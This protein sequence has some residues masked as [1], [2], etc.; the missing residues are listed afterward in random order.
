MH[1]EED[2]GKLTHVARRG[3]PCRRIWKRSRPQGGSRPYS[4]VDLNRAGVPL[5]E[6]VTEPDFRSAEEVRAYAESLRRLLRYLG[7]NSGDLEKG[8]LRVEPNI[9]VREA[10]QRD[11]WHARWRSRT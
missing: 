10:R 8:V 1:L 3:D 7:V 6:I 5:L 2:T 9:S 4:L 11:A